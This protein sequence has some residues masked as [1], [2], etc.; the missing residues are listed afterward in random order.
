MPDQTL[1]L[2]TDQV[3]AFVELARQGSLPAPADR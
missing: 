3:A 2:T 1:S